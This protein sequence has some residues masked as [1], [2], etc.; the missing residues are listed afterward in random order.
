MTDRMSD[1]LNKF[2]DDIKNLSVSN[3]ELPEG[4]LIEILNSLPNLKKLSFYDVSYN[5]TEKDNVGINLQYLRSFEIQL[6]NFIIPRTIT[7]FSSNTLEHLSI[8]NCILD[9]QTVT[10]ILNN[11]LNLIELEFD[12]YYC[13]PELLRNLQLR[14]LKL[15]SKRN[16]ISIIKSQQNY[17]TSLDL[18]KAHIGDNEFQEIC[19]IKSLNVLKLWIDQISWEIIENLMSLQHLHEL[20]LNYE[21]LEIEYVNIFSKLQLPSISTLQISFPKLKMISEHFISIAINCPSVTNLIIVCQSIGVI[22]TIIQYFHNLH[23]LKFGCDSDSVKVV[24]YFV[25]DDNLHNVSLRELYI[26]DNAYNN[27][28]REQF[29]SSS[30]LINLVR[31]SLPNLERLKIS[32]ILSLNIQM[33]KDILAGNHKLS[34]ISIEDVAVNFNFDTRVA[35]ELEALLIKLNYFHLSKVFVNLHDDAELLR[36]QLGKYFSHLSCKSWRNEIVFRN[37]KWHLDENDL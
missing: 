27:P 23:T 14:K 34:H 8:N 2:G 3:C 18:S 17:L 26:Y 16:A 37:N 11:Q 19:N 25:K 1:V 28:S 31:C 30:S 24:D 22:G 35:S 12:P 6:C 20:S 36:E 4:N 32:N 33:L 9:S 5:S 29:H 21:R 7:R 10:K 13:N 15:M